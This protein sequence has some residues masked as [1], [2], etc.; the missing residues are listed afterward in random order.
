M[1]CVLSSRRRHTR[2]ALVTGVQTC[3]PPICIEAMDPRE[4]PARAA[5]PTESHREVGVRDDRAV[6]R[7]ATVLEVAVK[8][9]EVTDAVAPVA[10]GVLG[11]ILQVGTFGPQLHA[12]HVLRSLDPLGRGLPQNGSAGCRDSGCQGG[13]Y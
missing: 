8:R 3:A 1:V 11:G 6:A 4:T 2:C 9:I 13:A 5:D 10:P 12:A 7:Q